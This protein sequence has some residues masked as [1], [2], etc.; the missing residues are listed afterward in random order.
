MGSS[1]SKIGTPKN[2]LQELQLK[3]I[4]REQKIKK[5]EKQQKALR[6][7]QEKNIKKQQKHQK[8]NQNTKN[9]REISESQQSYQLNQQEYELK[10]E[11]SLKHQLDN[12][13]CVFILNQMAFTLQF[14]GNFEREISAAY[15]YLW[16]QMENNLNQQF[17]EHS[18]LMSNALDA[19][20]EK[21]VRYKPMH[22]PEKYSFQ[23]LQPQTMYVVFENIDI[24]RPN[25]A[26]YDSLSPICK[27]DM[28]T[29]FYKTTPCS[30][31]YASILKSTKWKGYVRLML[32]NPH[33]GN[34]NGVVV[35]PKSIATSDEGI[36]FASESTISSSSVRR[37]DGFRYSNSSGYNSGPEYDYAY[38]THLNSHHPL[39]ELAMTNIQVDTKILPEPCVANF[40]DFIEIPDEDEED[41]EDEEALEEGLDFDEDFHL[42]HFSKFNYPPVKYL[43]SKEFMRYFAELL[44][45]KL[46][47]KLGLSED[48]FV[49]G[50]YRGASIHTKSYEIIPAIHVA[51]NAQNWP[52]C[53]FQFKRRERPTRTNPLTKKHFQ[54][55]TPEMI[56]RVETFGFHVIPMGH[57]PKR[58]RNPYREIEWKII[59]PKAERFLETTLTSTQIK[60]FMIAKALV[61]AFVE[62]HEK[63]NTLM[64]TMDHLRT[65]LFWECE[66]NYVTWP[67]EFLGGVLIRFIKAFMTRLREKCLPDFFIQE[68]NL[69]ESIPEYSL[70]RLHSAL[71]EIISNPVM[72]VMIALRNLYLVDDFIPKMDYKKIYNNLIECNYL[73]LKNLSKNSKIVP[74]LEGMKADLSGMLEETTDVHGL[75]GFAQQKEKIKGPMRRRT[76][77]MKQSIEMRRRKEFER[78][79]KSVDSIDLE[80]VFTKNF[81]D[82]DK[83]KDYNQGIENLRRTN[84]LE[85]ILDNLI[86]MGETYTKSKEYRSIY[87]ARIYLNQAKRLCKFYSGYG[88]DMGAIEYIS[89]IQTI[90]SQIAILSNTESNIPPPALP[91]RT[92]LEPLSSFRPPYMDSPK[93]KESRSD[94]YLC[95]S[96]L[97]QLESTKY[98]RE[99]RPSI[100]FANPI[101]ENPPKQH[102]TIKA[103]IHENDSNL[104]GYREPRRSIKFYDEA[105]SPTFI[106]QF[107][108][109]DWLQ[110][111]SSV[112]TEKPSKRNSEIR[113]HKPSLKPPQFKKKPRYPSSSSSDTDTDSE[114]AQRPPSFNKFDNNSL[115]VP[116]TSVP[117]RRTDS[118]QTPGLPPTTIES[119]KFKRQQHQYS[120]RSKLNPTKKES[121]LSAE[122]LNTKLN[123]VNFI[124]NTP[125][126]ILRFENGIADYQ[127]QH[128]PKR[129]SRLSSYSMDSPAVFEKRRTQLSLKNTESIILV[130][131]VNDTETSEL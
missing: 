100:K 19:A 26:N 88:C 44:R 113:I 122:A 72:H 75:I 3:E 63:D 34:A 24:A 131:G 52:D 21:R 93:V 53:A 92:S 49:N 67:E 118:I 109:N 41:E 46:A 66:K 74:L 68:R 36:Y 117:F 57:A 83:K 2:P 128:S 97:S 28:E 50:T 1:K 84:I 7:I 42:K 55:P 76:L 126:T 22:G 37:R 30:A 23:P 35:R 102:I 86:A 20:V 80:F 98:E 43:N 65:H 61:K 103:D 8:H 129:I 119:I 96:S 33:L 70:V 48:E 13:L 120:P 110:R 6:K 31:E 51:H 39:T 45:R 81:K 124:P 125:T 59:F 18:V 29:D 107:D 108:E 99:G 116:T 10:I 123:E 32:R 64:F 40:H 94:V 77:M 25:E 15:E 73:K 112:D 14:F 130:N 95:Q 85:I 71:A 16:K 27:V 9:D 82:S 79:R 12:D 89:K 17:E 58:Q 54:W 115:I 114:E 106:F 87:L 90:E 60:V 105:A 91:I 4:L 62:Q 11:Q 5:R 56:K 121:L 69:F 78:N 104:I 38:I 111:Q 101:E 47:P 127:L